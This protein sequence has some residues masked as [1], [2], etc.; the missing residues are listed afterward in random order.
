MPEKK[1]K[2]IA[3]AVDVD[4]RNMDEQLF[5][6]DDP[7]WLEKYNDGDLEEEDLTPRQ[8]AY[9]KRARSSDE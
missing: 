2:P 5:G 8:L 4:Q 7:D 3:T 9:L 6:D 1:Q